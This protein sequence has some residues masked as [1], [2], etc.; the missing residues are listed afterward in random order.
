MNEQSTNNITRIL[1]LS[2]EFHSAYIYWD[3]VGIIRHRTLG[4][5]LVFVNS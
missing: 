1:E 3:F 2:I 4:F 5:V